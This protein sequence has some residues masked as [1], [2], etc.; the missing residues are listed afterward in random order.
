[1]SCISEIELAGTTAESVIEYGDSH[2]EGREVGEVEEDRE[3]MIE[4]VLD[5]FHRLDYLSDIC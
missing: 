4:M 3:G 1:M 5:H 2:Q